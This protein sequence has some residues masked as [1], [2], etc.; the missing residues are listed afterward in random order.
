MCAVA[1]QVAPELQSSNNAHR[2]HLLLQHRH[3]HTRKLHAAASIPVIPDAKA[4]AAALLPTESPEMTLQDMLCA[5]ESYSPTGLQGLT[6]PPAYGG[7]NGSS[8]SSSSSQIQCKPPKLGLFQY[9]QVAFR[10]LV[11]PVVFHCE[12]GLCSTARCVIAVCL[13]PLCSC[14]LP[15]LL[16]TSPANH[17][18]SMSFFAARL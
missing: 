7:V 12:L 10:P 2:R 8:D 13:P 18:V 1:M 14:L 5:V 4:R 16:R 15:G 11:V 17:V 9:N 3:Q 6:L